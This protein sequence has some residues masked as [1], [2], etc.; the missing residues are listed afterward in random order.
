MPGTF[1][2]V[3]EKKNTKKTKTDEHYSATDVLTAYCTEMT[4]DRKRWMRDGGRGEEATW[5]GVI[6]A[7]TSPMWAHQSH[8]VRYR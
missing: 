6:I 4:I 3:K 7:A 1:S 2:T 8:D 5:A